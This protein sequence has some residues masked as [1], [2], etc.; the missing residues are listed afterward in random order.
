MQFL[1]TTTS[2]SVTSDHERIQVRTLTQT[3]VS[4]GLNAPDGISTLITVVNDI[5]GVEAEDVTLDL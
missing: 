4:I 2:Q 1:C 3:E 5:H